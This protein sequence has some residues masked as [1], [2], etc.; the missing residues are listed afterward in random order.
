M[1]EHIEQFNDYCARV[2]GYVVGRFEDHPVY[3]THDG[4]FVGR[5]NE[6]DPYNNLECALEVVDELVESVR[7]NTTG[8]WRNVV[9]PTLTSV[10]GR[11][12]I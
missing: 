7:S 8:T 9:F 5:K 4:Y 12:A 11:G 3:Y 1:S 6:Y 2:L 10:V